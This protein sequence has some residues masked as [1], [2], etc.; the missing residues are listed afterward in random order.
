MRSVTTTPFSALAARTQPLAVRAQ[1]QKHA[2]RALLAK[3]SLALAKDR[4]GSGG[5]L[6]PIKR[7]VIGL[8]FSSELP[9]RGCY[10]RCGVGS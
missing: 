7:M 8:L 1:V 6:R 2:A 5:Q 4:I 3:V 10:L 9:T